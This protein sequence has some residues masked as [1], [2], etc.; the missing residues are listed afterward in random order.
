MPVRVITPPSAVAGPTSSPL[1]VEP[2]SPIHVALFLGL[3]AGLV[4]V[5]LLAVAKFVLHRYPIYRGMHAVWATPVS[6]T[7]LLVAVAVPFAVLDRS[8]RRTLVRTAAMGTLAYLAAFDVLWLATQ[9]H[10]SARVALSAGLGASFIRIWGTNPARSAR[11]LHHGTRLLTAVVLLLGV[12]TSGLIR[13]QE[14][15]REAALPP[16]DPSAPNVLLLI[17]DTVRAANLGLYGYARATTPELTRLASR[18]VVFDRA[19]SSSSWTLPSHASI[20]TGRWAA[21]LSADWHSPLDARD[22]T[23]AEVFSRRGYRTAGFIANID[24]ANAESGLARGFMHYEDYRLTIAS[25]A[26]TSALGQYIRF[27]QGLR[28]LMHWSN[29]PGRKTASDLRQDVERWVRTHH[30][31][32]FFVFA[33]F[34]DAHT[35]YLP[36]PPY[37]TL[38]TGRRLRWEDRD[39]F[40][41]PGHLP[42]PQILRNEEAMYD[43]AIA[44]IDA[45]LGRLLADLDASGALRNT[46]VIVTADH[47]EE[48]GEHGVW[49]HGYGLYL[50]SL[51]VPLVIVAPRGVPA[52]ARVPQWISLRD[53]AATIVD[54][55]G[56]PT[57]MPGRSLARYWNGARASDTLFAEVRHASNL[58]ATMPVSRGDVKSALGGNWQLITVGAREQELFDLATDSLETR[59]RSRD[60][61]IPLARLGEALRH[62]PSR[63]LR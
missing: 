35:P 28:T 12:V 62:G 37:D 54:L 5:A 59:N 11:W 6:L 9:L 2:P 39:R 36:P 32:P 50:S 10:W 63:R 15:R 1:G 55:A 20:F 47:G 27:H 34:Y 8:R 19:L 21:E 22:P 52:A 42:S 17:L 23:L 51:R 38:F 3:A 30:D 18:G 58:P 26:V 43:G 56:A 24:F 48:F 41:D 49:G 31:R 14:A 45:E 4:E 29:F 7:L 16:S 25:I 60:A 61:P 33:N 57:S 46:I 44:S 40:D 53:L 13:V